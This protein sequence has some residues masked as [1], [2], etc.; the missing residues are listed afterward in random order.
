LSGSHKTYGLGRFGNGL[1]IAL[2]YGFACCPACLYI[3]AGTGMIRSN[4]M[5]KHFWEEVIPSR[6][7]GGDTVVKHAIRCRVCERQKIVADQ[8]LPYFANQECPG[9]PPPIVLDNQSL[10]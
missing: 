1:G 7:F 8:D 4:N 3:F 9:N 10:T 6:V 5:A 2:T